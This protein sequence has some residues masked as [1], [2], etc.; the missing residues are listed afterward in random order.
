M[1]LYLNGKRSHLPK[2][3][4]ASSPPT[5]APFVKPLRA[6]HIPLKARMCTKLIHQYGCG[7]KLAE[8]A[9][10]AALKG[11]GCKGKVEKKVVHVTKCQKCGG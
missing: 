4:Q 8:T 3:L 5:P 7:H 6:I 10:C 9:P 11:G 1:S 2:L